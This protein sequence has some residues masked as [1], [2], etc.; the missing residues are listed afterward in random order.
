MLPKFSNEYVISTILDCLQTPGLPTSVEVKLAS[1]I[2]LKPRA[3]YQS[4]PN[5]DHIYAV[6]VAMA[7]YLDAIDV[8]D[9]EGS[10]E[11]GHLC[12]MVL[13]LMLSDNPDSPIATFGS[14]EYH[15]IADARDSIVNMYR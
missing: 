11:L 10:W 9:S 4:Q 1:L 13:Q 5:D 7:D 2:G 15:T 6:S 8:E 14:H 12:E 3:N